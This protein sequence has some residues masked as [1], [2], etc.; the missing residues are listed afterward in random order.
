MVALAAGTVATC[1]FAQVNNPEVEANEDK[2]TATV[3]ASGGAGMANGDFITGNTTGTST[4]IA[5]A[6]SADIFRVKTAAAPLGIYRNRLVLTTTGTAGHVGTILG[7]NQSTVGILTTVATL[8]TSSSTTAPGR[9]NQ[10]YGFGKQEEVFYRV[11]GIA[12]TTADYTSTLEVTPVTPISGPTL[13]PGS[14][15]FN[16]VGITSID[17]DLWVYDS[18]FNAIANFCPKCA[19]PMPKSQSH[20]S[21][22][23]GAM[24][25]PEPKEQ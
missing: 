3:A 25:L 18:N 7:L 23:G 20:C 17:T 22:C 14:I 10:W 9:M 5:G 4:T 12:A 16:T 1:A 21:K 24:I 19:L 6:G 15:R 8:Q 2:T 11:T 13:P